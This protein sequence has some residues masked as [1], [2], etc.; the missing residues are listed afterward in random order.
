G[1]VY[2][3][4]RKKVEE[5][6][7]W[8]SS[9]GV[10]SLPY[11]AG[12]GAEQRRKHQERFLREDGL[13]VCATIAF[14]MGIDKPDVRFVAH[15][16]L[17]KSVEGYYQETGRGGRDGEPASAWMAYGLGD[18]VQ[19]RRFIE[20]GEGAPSF[21]RLQQMKLTQ[22]LGLCEGVDCRRRMLLAYFGEAHAGACGNCDNCLG[23]AATFDGT[24]AAQ[25]ALSTVARTGSRFGAG[26]LVDVLLGK[27]TEKTLRSGHETLSVWGIGGDFS[28]Q[29]WS[30]VYRQLVAG[31]WVDVDAEA[32]GALKLNEKSWDILK[33]GV[34]LSLREDVQPK[35]GRTKAGRGKAAIGTGAPKRSPS[36]GDRE[37]EV[38]E[39]LRALRRRLAD[40]QNL[41][42][43]VVFHDSTL[44]EMVALKPRTLDEL[45]RVNGVGEAKLGKYGKQFLEAL[46]G[47][48][49]GD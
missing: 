36:L 11:H 6:A 27:S 35:A 2:C 19:L 16:D 3:L 40:E 18:V 45:A 39:V 26:H 15:L 20:Q 14:G 30:S 21:K 9:K 43:Y 46:A 41:P 49:V 23:H 1:I 38:F 5:T 8:L 4:S 24:L 7:D 42:S 32:Y 28:A 37:A 29:R 47:V 33:R 10:A 44:W 12:L 48:F 13:V 25:K 17:P 22:M 31:G 34:T